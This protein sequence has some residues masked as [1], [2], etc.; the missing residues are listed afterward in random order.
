MNSHNLNLKDN[1][2]DTNMFDMYSNT[3][4]VSNRELNSNSP[5][6]ISTSQAL[7]GVVRFFN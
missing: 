5:S 4:R 3:G 6:K 1:V 7:L 2:E